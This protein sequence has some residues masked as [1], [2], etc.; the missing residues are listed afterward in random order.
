MK[1]RNIHLWIGLIASFLIFLEVVTGLLLVHTNWLKF[2]TKT[3]TYSA[4]QYTD[5]VNVVQALDRAAKSGQFSVDEIRLVMNHTLGDGHHG[6][7]GNY[8]IR[9]RDQDQTLYVFDT[10]GNLIR[11]EVN[12]TNNVIRDFHYG[13]LEGYDLSWL[14]DII[15]I[16]VAFLTIT[17]VYLGICDL[18]HKKRKK[19]QSS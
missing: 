3:T 9:L 15:A 12:V 16:S 8:K 11:K 2:D 7:A 1:I 19:T 10:K 6:K 14:L 17:G 5:D 4:Q 18:L 13:E